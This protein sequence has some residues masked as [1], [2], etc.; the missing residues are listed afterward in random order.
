MVIHPLVRDLYKRVLMVSKD[1]P[2]NDHQHVKSLW[3]TALRNPDNCPSWYTRTEVS[4]HQRNTSHD[5]NTTTTTTNN[6]RHRNDIDELLHAVH[7]GRQMVQEMMGIIQLH[8]YRTMKQ[9]YHRTTGSTDDTTRIAAN[10]L[11]TKYQ[12]DTLD[13]TKP[14]N[15]TKTTHVET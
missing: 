9:R 1:Y 5:S 4:T 14:N 7:R 6:H 15:A 8:K 13:Q 3:K 12:N 10:E 2:S 11:F